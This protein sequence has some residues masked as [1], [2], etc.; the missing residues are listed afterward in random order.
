MPPRTNRDK[1][2]ALWRDVLTEGVAAKRFKC[3][4]PAD[5]AAH[6]WHY[7][8]DAHLTPGWSPCHR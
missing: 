4:D 7:E 1:F 3:D 5:G 6:P 2:E 8:L